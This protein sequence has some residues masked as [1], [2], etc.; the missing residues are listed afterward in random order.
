MPARHI[1][2][3]QKK[4]ITTIWSGAAIDSDL[5]AALCKYKEEI[6]MKGGY[7][8]YNEILDFTG[9]DNYKVTVE[10]IKQL[11]QI[12]VSTDVAGIKTKLAIIVTKPVAFG[13]GRMYQTYRSLMPGEGKEVC[14]YR[15]HREALEW[16]ES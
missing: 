10:G 1:I 9:V 13:L 2:D 6:I 3:D 7:H 14:I 12:A 16:V 15:T 8:S 11:A 5:I 4:L